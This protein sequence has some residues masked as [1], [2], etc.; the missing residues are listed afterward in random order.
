MLAADPLKK[1]FLLKSQSKMEGVS[2]PLSY[3]SSAALSQSYFR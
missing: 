3:I 1:L 2:S